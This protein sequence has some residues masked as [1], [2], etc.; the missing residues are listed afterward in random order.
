VSR[1][2]GPTPSRTI[3]ASDAPGAARPR[4]FTVRPGRD[5]GPK[6]HR[7]VATRYKLAV[8]Y[9]A[10]VLATAINEWLLGAR[11]HGQVCDGSWSSRPTA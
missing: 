11:S 5:K 9:E 4:R 8:H 3:T 7:A 6:G 10:T 2:V 1:R